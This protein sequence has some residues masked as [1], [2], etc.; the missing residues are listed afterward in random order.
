MHNWGVKSAQYA[1]AHEARQLHTAQQIEWKARRRRALIED[2]DACPETNGWINYSFDGFCRKQLI[3][4][5]IRWNAA[6]ARV[7]AA[8]MTHNEEG[9]DDEIPRT[10]Q[11]RCHVDR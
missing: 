4:I 1:N 3:D 6:V 2:E 10:S 9:W 11:Y 5:E 8:Q 7:R